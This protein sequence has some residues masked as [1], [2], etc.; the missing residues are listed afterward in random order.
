MLAAVAVVLA[1]AMRHLIP[2]TTNMLSPMH[3]PI[4]L[5]GIL[6]GQWYGLIGGVLTPFLSFL[7]SGMPPFPDPLIPMMVELAAYGF[8]TGLF[9]KVF[10]KNPKTNKFA[11]VIALVI[12]MVV[13]RALNA[14]VGAAFLGEGET[15]FGVLWTEF[16]GNFTHTWVGI[17]IQLVLIPAILFALQKGGILI[18][19]LPDTPTATKT[20]DSV[21]ATETA[22]SEN[23]TDNSKE[24]GE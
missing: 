23:A 2:G 12:A 19:Y 9:R 5:L 21:A 4:L 24:T 6:C 7:T 14:V 22:E 15:Y 18:K 13:G 3:F 10:L 20:A 1:N 17:I 11:S 16:L 8:F